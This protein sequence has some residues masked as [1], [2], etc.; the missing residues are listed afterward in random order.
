MIFSLNLLLSLLSS[1]SSNFSG[2][3][4]AFSWAEKELDM[5]DVF[6]QSWRRFIRKIE[7]NED[8]GSIYSTP[9]QLEARLDFLSSLVSHPFPVKTFTLTCEFV[10]EIWES[11]VVNSKLQLVLKN[12]GFTW[13]DLQ[14]GI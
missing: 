11:L 1:P 9:K 8:L 7:L 2:D 3:L 6:F 10:E 12:K 5:M 13:F 4:S 14:V